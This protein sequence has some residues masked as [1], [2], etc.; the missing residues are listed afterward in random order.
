VNGRLE[1]QGLL[2]KPFEALEEVHREPAQASEHKLVFVR[3]GMGVMELCKKDAEKALKRF[4][5]TILTVV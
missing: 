4:G 3:I 5:D 2:L 1:L